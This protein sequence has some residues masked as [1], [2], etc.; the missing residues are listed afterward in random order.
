M[1][2]Q[3]GTGASH[4]Q[5]INSENK[6]EVAA[7]SRSKEHHANVV[8]GNA[9]NFEFSVTPGA[10]KTFLYLKNSSDLD[11]IAEGFSIRV[12]SNEQISVHLAEI[13]TPVGGSDIIPA[14]L[15]AGSNKQAIG[16]F[17]TGTDITGLT[18]GRE[19]M[20]FYMNKYV[21][22]VEVIGMK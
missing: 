15:N 8:H 18:G 3:D 1:K 21:L 5:K 14:N 12:P 9:Y 20:K 10:G 13:G 16:T 22:V 11:I 4:W 6:A 2:V 17:Q 7:I 19:I